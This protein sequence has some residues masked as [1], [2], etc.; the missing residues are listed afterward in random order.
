MY[1][2]S[3]IE[4]WYWPMAQHV[5]S[6]EDMYDYVYVELSVPQ[7]YKDSSRFGDLSD[8][9]FE[10]TYMYLD[11]VLKSGYGAPMVNL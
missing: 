7:Q 8:V 4:P 1:I 5:A 6:D 3:N 10:S 11:D 9:R 2:G